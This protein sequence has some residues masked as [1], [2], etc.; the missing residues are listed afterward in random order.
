MLDYIKNYKNI[1]ICAHAFNGDTLKECD[2]VSLTFAIQCA[3][4]I[5]RTICTNTYDDEIQYARIFNSDIIKD[6][7]QVVESPEELADFFNKFKPKDKPAIALE[8]TSHGFARWAKVSAKGTI[9]VYYHT[10]G[11]SYREEIPLPDN[12]TVT[13]DASPSWMGDRYQCNVFWNGADAMKS[14][15][16]DAV[17]QLTRI[18]EFCKREKAKDEKELAAGANVLAK[19]AAFQE[20]SKSVEERIATTWNAMSTED[21]AKALKISTTKKATSKKKKK[22]KK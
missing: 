20:Q 19:L 22:A 7:E 6:T 10:I 11:E 21:K 1:H 9:V 16:D 5:W 14:L 4:G 3:D 12:G 18:Q 13:R 15:W 8:T 2:R 17:K